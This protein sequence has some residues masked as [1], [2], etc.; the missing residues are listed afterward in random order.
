MPPQFPHCLWHLL[1]LTASMVDAAGDGVRSCICL[2]CLMLASCAFAVSNACARV[3]VASF[4]KA[5]AG[6][7]DGHSC[8]ELFQ[9]SL[10]CDIFRYVFAFQ[11]LRVYANV[12][13]F[14]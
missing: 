6:P 9:D 4:D 10:L 3:R 8:Y 5:H 13:A 12:E 7:L 11:H 1:L 2:V 14:H